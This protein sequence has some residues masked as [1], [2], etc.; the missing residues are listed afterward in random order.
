MEHEGLVRE[1]EAVAEDNGKLHLEYENLKARE[2]ALIG[3][4][5]Q[6]LQDAKEKLDLVCLFR[7]H[8]FSS[9]LNH[10]VGRSAE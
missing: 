4:H 7:T 2:H 1:R 10:I 9:V 6:E 3:A 8:T 5:A